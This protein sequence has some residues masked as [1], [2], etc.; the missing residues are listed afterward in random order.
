[1]VLIAISAN[2]RIATGQNVKEQSIPI[3]DNINKILEASCM[4]CHGSNGGMMPLAKLDLSKWAEY[5]PAKKAEKASRIC[6]VLTEQIM[7]PKSRRKSNP[8]L[9]PTKEQSGLICKWAAS[10]NTNEE[11]K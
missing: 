5:S 9:I 6:Y 10:L 2:I 3:P 7:P 11:K 1:M 8:E 4:P